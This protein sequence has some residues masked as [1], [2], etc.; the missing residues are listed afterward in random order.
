MLADGAALFVDGRYTLQAREQIDPDMF[1]IVQVPETTPDVGVWDLTDEGKYWRIHGVSRQQCRAAVEQP[2]S[3]HHR[4]GLRLAGRERR[5]KRH[6]GGA[7]FVP[8]MHGADT[9]SGLE[10]CVKEVVV[11]D[12]GQAVDGIN[13][14]GEERGD[15]RL[16]GGHRLHGYSTG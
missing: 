6:I 10:Q 3:G 5:A 9:S 15:G 16:G 11:V 7:L 13:A 1:A 8:R 12:P 14:M 4:I 2:W